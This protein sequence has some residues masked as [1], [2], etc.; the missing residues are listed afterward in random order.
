MS[1]T[2]VTLPSPSQPA[3]PVAITF[4]TPGTP[5]A[6]GDVTIP[7]PG[8]PAEPSPVVLP[9]TGTGGS[10]PAAPVVVVEPTPTAPAAPGLITQPTPTAPAAPGLITEPTP[11][12]PAAPGAAVLTPGMNAPQSVTPTQVAHQIAA[13]VKPMTVALEAGV[14]TGVLDITALGLS[15]PPAHA[16]FLSLQ[17]HAPGDANITGSVIQS[18]ITTTSVPFEL[19]APTDNAQRIAVILV[20]P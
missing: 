20:I 4:P 19:S 12:P 17:K 10:A 11:A 16:S 6:P 13:A 5:A 2:S 14:D 18:E 15:V 1:T 8:T 7:A 9:G 3:D